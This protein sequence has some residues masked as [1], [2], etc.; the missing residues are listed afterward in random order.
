M[1]DTVG[2][3][4]PQDLREFSR[5]SALLYCLGIVEFPRCGKNRSNILCQACDKKGNS[6]DL[7]RESGPHVMCSYHNFSKCHESSVGNL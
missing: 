3:I 2:N 5:L 7:L 1:D 6:L 4:W